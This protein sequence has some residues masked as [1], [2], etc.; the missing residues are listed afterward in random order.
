M[1]L[2]HCLACRD[3]AKKLE[4]EILLEGRLKSSAQAGASNGK[5][6]HE[7]DEEVPRNR[8]SRGAGRSYDRMHS[9]SPSPDRDRYRD[10][11]RKRK[12]YSRSRSPDRDRQA[13]LLTH[14]RRL[15]SARM[16][17]EGLGTSQRPDVAMALGGPPSMAETCL[18]HF[19]R[20]HLTAPLCLWLQRRGGGIAWV[21]PVM[22]SEL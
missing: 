5:A 7:S 6:G 13:Q 21:L 20:L 18:L 12:R 15:C 3:H 9:R 8:A 2:Q 17:P 16:R 10:D 22:L 4:E 14:R 1:I 11:R 19:A